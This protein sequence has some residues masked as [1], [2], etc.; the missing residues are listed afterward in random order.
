MKT[1]DNN[2]I[3]RMIVGALALLAL[4]SCGKKSADNSDGVGNPYGYL[5]SPNCSGCF[6]NGSA[7][8]SQVGSKTI[9]GDLVFNLDII[10]Q[11]YTQSPN[12]TLVYQPFPGTQYQ[13]NPISTYN[14][15]IALQ[16]VL[17]VA[18]GQND[19]T[20]CYVRS[21]RFQI[22]TLRA[23][24]ANAGFISNVAVEGIAA[25]GQRLTLEIFQAVLVA[26]P[27]NV[28]LGQNLPGSRLGMNFRITSVNGQPCSSLISTY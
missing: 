15:S 20:L 10:G 24:Q 28:P 16:G 7:I 18:S 9:R 27:Q 14:G 22:S 21:G 4:V 5:V 8:V 26:P 19:F 12:T 23:G 2:T 11:N 17:D 3:K 13:Q 1:L 6:T 25:D